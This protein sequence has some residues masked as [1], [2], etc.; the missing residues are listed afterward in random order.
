LD[1]LEAK[2]ELALSFGLPF[3]CQR[4]NVLKDGAQ[5]VRVSLTLIDFFI[6][7]LGPEYWLEDVVVRVTL[8]SSEFRVLEIDSFHLLICGHHFAHVHYWLAGSHS[9]IQ[10]LI[11]FFHLWRFSFHCW[12]R[13][14]HARLC[15]VAVPL[16]EVTWAMRFLG[17]GN[18][19]VDIESLLPDDWLERLDALLDCK[20]VTRSWSVF[21][22]R[23]GFGALVRHPIIDK[24]RVWVILLKLITAFRFA[25]LINLFND[26]VGVGVVLL[27]HVCFS[28]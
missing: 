8:P 13:E 11:F 18:R 17:G 14:G 26:D 19:L 28:V 3:G 5:G 20:D 9:I 6:T 21:V 22:L 7:S 25:F 27:Q 1:F 4:V 15:C 24:E 23:G 2:L 12:S 10:P 16:E